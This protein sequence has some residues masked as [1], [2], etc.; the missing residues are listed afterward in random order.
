[1]VDTER[2]IWKEVSINPNYLVSNFG[3]VK[4]KERLVP[5]KGGKFRKK[6]GTFLNSLQ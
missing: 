5:M 6:K 4:S 1:M 3:R 2:E